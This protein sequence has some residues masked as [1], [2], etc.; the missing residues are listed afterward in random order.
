M[1][2]IINIGLAGVKHDTVTIE[3]NDTFPFIIIH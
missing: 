1:V 3:N 2:V